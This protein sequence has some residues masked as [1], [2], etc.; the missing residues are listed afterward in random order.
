MTLPALTFTLPANAT[1]GVG[2][3]AATVSIPAAPAAPLSVALASGDTGR[4]TVPAAATIPAGLTS[5][6]VPMTIIDNTLLDGIE[7]VTITALAAGYAGASGTIIVHDNETATLVLSLPASAWETA[8]VLAGAGTVASNRAPTRD[9]V[10]HLLSNY[11]NGLTVPATVTLPAGQTSVHFDVTMHYDQLIEGDRPVLV[12]ATVE[13]WTTGSAT[14]VDL[15]SDVPS[16]PSPANGVANAP[17]STGL[18]W[19]GTQSAVVTDTVSSSFSS[20]TDSSDATGDYYAATS[21]RML[22]QIEVYLG[23][24][25]STDLQFFVYESTIS[26][27]TYTRILDQERPGF[28]H[29]NQVVQLGSD[30]RFPGLREV[31]LHR[32]LLARQRD[33]LL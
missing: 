25:T 20:D 7:T 6:S 17:L 26:G 19:T 33:L 2:T 10:V 23:I 27:G 1:E 18:S 24:G 28:R 14:L 13:N 4:A 15:D 22:R 9:I 32:S 3:V 12:A 29:G 30:L 8:G 11:T 16:T 21:T 31:L 5:A